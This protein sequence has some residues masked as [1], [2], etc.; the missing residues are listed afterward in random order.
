MLFSSD[1]S[2]TCHDWT[3]KVGADG[4]PRV[5]HS[6][7]RMGGGGGMRG[8]GSADNWMSAL[9]E[10]GCAAGASLVEIGAPQSRHADSGLGRRL[11]RNL[12]LCADSVMQLTRAQNVIFWRPITRSVPRQPGQSTLFGGGVTV[13]TWISLCALIGL[14]GC[15]ESRQYFRPTEHVYGQTV[16]GEREAIYNMV[17]SFGPFGEAKVWSRGSFL[18]D[19]EAVVYVTIDLHNTSGVLIIIDPQDVRLD[20]LRAGEALLRDVAPLEHKRLSV[21]PGAFGSVRLSFALPN[22]VV[23]GQISSFGLRWKVQNGPQHYAQRTPFIEERG[24]NYYYSGHPAPAYGYGFGMYGCGWDNPWCAGRTATG[25]GL[26]WV[27]SVMAWAEAAR[28]LF[29]HLRPCASRATYATCVSG[30]PRRT[31][32]TAKR[33]ARSARQPAPTLTAR[34]ASYP[35]SSTAWASPRAGARTVC[36]QQLHIALVRA[37]PEIEHVTDKGHAADS[38]IDRD[39]HT[40]R[41][42]TQTGSR[43]CN[44]S[45]STDSDKTPPTASPPPGNNIPMIGSS[46][47]RSFVPGIVSAVSDQYTTRSTMRNNGES[48]RQRPSPGVSEAEPVDVARCSGEALMKSGVVLTPP[49]VKHRGAAIARGGVWAPGL[50][51]GLRAGGD[52]V[53][54]CTGTGTGTGAGRSQRHSRGGVAQDVTRYDLG[55]RIGKTGRRYV[56]TTTEVSSRVRHGEIARNVIATS[57]S[58]RA[59]H[60]HPMRNTFQKSQTARPSAR[61]QHSLVRG[62]WLRCP[63]NMAAKAF[64]GRDSSVI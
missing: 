6:W 46:P 53:A 26:A 34:A 13:R 35:R 61:F 58:P 30:L 63:K 56:C 28:L 36:A 11:R 31:T 14:M 15:A 38:G 44:A 60:A 22:R 54:A 43:F 45:S 59:L 64:A 17:G 51:S 40:I 16:R 7:P 4:K 32:R 5:G 55:S 25:W 1:W 52:G 12:L 9:D 41:P 33:R 8:G 19:G 10:A 27:A 21:A 42:S 23:P 18:E 3:S 47:K 50:S 2:S 37:E 62:S 20:P 24:N 49:C 57:G 29:R 39:V 48:C